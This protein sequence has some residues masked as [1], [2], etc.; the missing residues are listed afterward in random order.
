MGRWISNARYLTDR[1]QVQLWLGWQN[2]PACISV[3]CIIDGACLVLCC[4]MM[5]LLLL[6]LFIIYWPLLFY[7][8]FCVDG[9]VVCSVY[10]MNADYGD[11][12][13]FS[14]V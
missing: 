6:L 13:C 4:V 8:F 3:C 1:Q 14:I 9:G 5:Y 2:C 7:Y 12:S 11:D 10:V